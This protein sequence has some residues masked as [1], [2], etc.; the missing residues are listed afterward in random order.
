MRKRKTTRKQTAAKLLQG[1]EGVDWLQLV[2]RGATFLREM[3][4]DGAAVIQADSL[5]ELVRSRRVRET[6]ERFA[7]GIGGAES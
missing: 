4:G 1:L 5:R 7:S 6:V 3:R 2:Q